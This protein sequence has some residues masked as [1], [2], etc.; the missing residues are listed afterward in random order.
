MRKHKNKERLNIG[1]LG[2]A[3]ALFILAY[4]VFYLLHRFFS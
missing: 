4:S 1:N 3:M 2:Y